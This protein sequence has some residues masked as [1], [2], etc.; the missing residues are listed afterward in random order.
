[1]PSTKPVSGDLWMEDL[2]ASFTTYEQLVFEGI[3]DL[4]AGETRCK[5]IVTNRR[6]PEPAR[7]SVHL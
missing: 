1:M 5:N 6:L 2:A 4:N 7:S 3:T